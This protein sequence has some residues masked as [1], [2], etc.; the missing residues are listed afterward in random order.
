MTKKIVVTVLVVVLA[1]V[2][3][4]CA[5]QTP[6]PIED[7]TQAPTTVP[8][9][10]PTQAPTT[11]P[12]VAPTSPPPVVD[13]GKDDDDVD[14]PTTDPVKIDEYQ[15]L[16]SAEN[17]YWYNRILG[18]T[19]EDPKDISLEYLFYN[20]LPAEP[21]ESQ[22]S[23][24]T[25]LNPYTDSEMA[26]LKAF[27]QDKFGDEVVWT[28]NHKLRREAVNE[29][30]VTYLGV[31][32]EDVTIPESWRYFDETDAYYDIHTDAILLRNFRVI[33]VQEYDDGKVEIFWT[34]DFH[35]NTMTENYETEAEM[36]LTLMKVDDHFIA[37]SNMPL[38]ETEK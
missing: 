23:D 5:S 11:E 36:L 29:V 14:E 31:T 25:G 35:Y 27:A 15:Q 38:P 30:L 37:L 4:Y 9:A 18:C 2:L 34:V 21:S 24:P 8:T 33:H 17:N 6:E 19:F 22:D 10:A 28:N 26:F 13:H 3:A 1:L 16:L 12:T 20:G 32:L 7:P